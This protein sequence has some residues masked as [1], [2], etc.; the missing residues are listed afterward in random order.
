MHP[1][2]YKDDDDQAATTQPLRAAPLPA[3]CSDTPPPKARPTPRQLRAEGRT[4]R[5]TVC[6]NMVS[7]LR[8]SPDCSS[9]PIWIS[10]WPTIEYV[11]AVEALMAAEQWRTK[12]VIQPAGFSARPR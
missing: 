9:H 7:F 5:A 2:A 4:R 11:D 6:H 12:C 10:A 1:S 8:L 3:T